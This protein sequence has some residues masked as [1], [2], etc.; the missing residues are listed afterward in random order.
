MLKFR[1][2]VDG[3]DAQKAELR[4]LNEAAEGFFKIADD[5]RVTRVGRFLRQPCLDELPQLVNVLRGR[6]EPRRPAPAGAG[7]GPPHRGLAARPPDC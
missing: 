5:P 7:R 2:M 3:A 1:T 4:E 6:D